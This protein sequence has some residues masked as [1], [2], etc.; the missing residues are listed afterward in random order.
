MPKLRER[1]PKT[2]RFGDDET[3]LLQNRHAALKHK[4]SKTDQ[5]IPW[6]TFTEFFHAILSVAPADYLP[7]RYHLNWG[8]KGSD[9]RLESL[10]FRR[11]LA[12][13]QCAVSA[14][15]ATAFMTL[16]E[17][18]PVELADFINTAAAHAAA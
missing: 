12:A 4:L 11:I 2:E 6:P 10:R 5:E 16:E 9:Y 15:L 7:S 14:E 17:G 3:R 18:E 1:L 13:D 8:D